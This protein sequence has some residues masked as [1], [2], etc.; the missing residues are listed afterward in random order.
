MHDIWEQSMLFYNLQAEGRKYCTYIG[1]SFFHLRVIERHRPFSFH[2]IDLMLTIK[3]PWHDWRSQSVLLFRVVRL[4][5]I[6]LDQIF[7]KTRELVFEILR[8]KYITKI[9]ATGYR[10][11]Y[12]RFAAAK[13]MQDIS[14]NMLSLLY[15]GTMIM[16]FMRVAYWNIMNES[17]I[18]WVEQIAI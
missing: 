8:K 6:V 10:L 9:S 17:R 2:G 5:F 4:R 11:I 14:K 12:S 7:F 15:I 1:Y 3:K 18:R 16:Y 13:L